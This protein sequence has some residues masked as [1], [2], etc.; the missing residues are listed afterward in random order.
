MKERFEILNYKYRIVILTFLFFLIITT[1][2]P[3]SGEDLG[4]YLV[5]K[6]NIFDNINILDGRI[7]TGLLVPFFCSNKILFNIVFSLLISLFVYECNNVLG[8]VKCKYYY[9]LPFFNILLVSVF[10][11]SYSYMSVSST[12]TYTF[13]TLIIFIYFLE[14]VKREDYLFKFKDYALISLVVL[15]VSFSSVFIAL[16]FALTNFLFYLLCLKRKKNIS[17]V[18]ILILILQTLAVII[19]FAFIDKVFFYEN[20]N[21]ML[22]FLPSYIDN[23]FSKN[24]VFVFLSI[25]PINYYLNEK[26]GDFV[27][28][29]VIITF[30]DA[31]V[32]FSITYNF[33]YYVPVNMN[34]VISK[35]FGVFATENWYYIFYYLIY[36]VLYFC[37]IRYFVKA[38]KVKDILTI[39]YLSTIF[40]NIFNLL[41]PMWD[42]GNTVYNVFFMILSLSVLFKDI[43]IKIYPKFTILMLT[44]LIFYY[45]SMFGITKYIDKTREEYI[46]EQVEA[47]SKIIEVKANPLY[48]VWRY[49]P[50]NFFQEKDFKLYYDIPEDSQIEVKYFGIF[51]KIKN[52]VKE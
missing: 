34:L 21:K 28:K 26:L 39:L 42:V 35:Y 51:E 33:Y 18:Y 17:N 40:L 49:N 46:D 38:K 31:I 47:K 45:A 4:Y 8:V 5:G 9:L 27:Y 50:V 1:L 19:S 13:P 3:L 24:I 22:S 7:I 16:T 29:R 25:I 32:V 20:I 23:V 10:T 12:V 11:F 36:Y 37:T 30:F 48:L 43:E 15:Y 6:E 52:K 14:L 44:L 2:C 41:S